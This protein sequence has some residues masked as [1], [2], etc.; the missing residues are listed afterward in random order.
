MEFNKTKQK[1]CNFA[2]IND[3]MTYINDR[4]V[5]LGQSN[6]ILLVGCNI[7]LYIHRYP[8]IDGKSPSSH[9]VTALPSKHDELSCLGETK[10]WKYILLGPLTVLK[11]WGALQRML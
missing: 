2:F 6:Y 3:L 11:E 5:Q 10:N 8:N 4:K 9:V 7:Y 1:A